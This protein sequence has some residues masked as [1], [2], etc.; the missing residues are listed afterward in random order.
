M[1]IERKFL[2]CVRPPFVTSGTSARLRQGYLV[3]CSDG[4]TRIRDADG[5]LTLTVKSVGGLSRSEHE[6]GITTAQFDMLWPATVGRRVQKRRYRVPLDGLMAEVDVYEEGLAG[7]EVV[8]V[9]FTSE[10][11]A[12]AFA[13]PEW[14]G[15]ELTDD[16]HYRNAALALRGLPD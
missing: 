15:R 12:A 1:E 13:P 3:E 11:E 8:E 10:A 4:E 2:V 7:L 14:F 6:I 9:E 16:P 5:V